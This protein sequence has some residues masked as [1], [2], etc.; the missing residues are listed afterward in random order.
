MIA[1]I[2]LGNP[3]SKY[4]ETRHNV[5]FR[6]ID[7]L[8]KT[9]ELT[10]VNQD[11]LEFKK[12]SSLK[13]QIAKSHYKE[14][15][16]IL[17]KPTTFV[18]SSGQTVKKIS[19]K[20]NLDLKDIWVI[21]DDLDIPISMVRSRDGG[22]SGGHNGV[23][24]IINSLGSQGF[25]RIRIG[26]GPVKG[27]GKEKLEIKKPANSKRFVLDKFSKR[28]E[29][30]LEGVMEKTVEFLINSIKKGKLTATTIKH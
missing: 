27:F 26:I 2:G 23:E 8:A 19:S 29:E 20:Y 6:I 13:A 18:N 11:Q 4:S 16:V 9:K 17:V 1:L 10:A 15:D 28:E 14:S 7:E 24:D 12:D 25:P 3:G 30:I 21:H 5:G 22:S